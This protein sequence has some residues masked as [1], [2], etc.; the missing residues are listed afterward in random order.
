MMQVHQGTSYD[1]SIGTSRQ[2][3]K[4]EFAFLMQMCPALQQLYWFEQWT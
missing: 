4:H 3:K 1:S 2:G